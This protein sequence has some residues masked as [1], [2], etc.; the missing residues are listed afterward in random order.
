MRMLRG[1][2]QPKYVSRLDLGLW[3][4]TCH[5]PVELLPHPPLQLHRTRVRDA[6]PAPRIKC[7]TVPFRV[8]KDVEEKGVV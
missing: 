8:F 7:V 6:T 1:E 2:S 3:A 4:D 5:W